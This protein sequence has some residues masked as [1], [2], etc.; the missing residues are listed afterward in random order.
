MWLINRNK[1]P[2]MSNKN[3]RRAEVTNVLE[4]IVVSCYIGACSRIKRDKISSQAWSTYVNLIINIAL[5]GARLTRRA[6]KQEIREYLFR[7]SLADRM[8]IPC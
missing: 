1:L 8:F 4:L 2:R 5:L 7:L 3:I 6:H